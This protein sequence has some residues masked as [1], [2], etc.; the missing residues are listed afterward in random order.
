MP[1]FPVHRRAAPFLLLAI[2]LRKETPVTRSDSLPGARRAAS[3]L[4]LLG[5][6]LCAAGAAVAQSPASIPP[7]AHSDRF[8]GDWSCDRGYREANGGC[9][10]VS[11]PDNAYAT[12]RSYGSGWECKR[13]YR[14]VGEKCAPL[15]VPANAYL[16]ST[17]DRWKCARGFQEVDNRCDAITVPANGFLSDSAIGSGWACDRGFR[18]KGNACAAIVVPENAYLSDTSFGPGWTCER[19]FR[20]VADRC[21]AVVLR[22]NTHLD[23]SGQNWECDAPYVKRSGRCELPR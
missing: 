5:A 15:D 16:N 10:A 12:N 2:T 6:L 9:V 7:N 18:P 8:G 20:A 13:G 14:T 3:G 19:G 23:Y 11:I 1:G 21:D 4:A 22:E 17:G